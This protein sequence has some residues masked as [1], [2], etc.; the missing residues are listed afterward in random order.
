MTTSAAVTA[1]RRV[2]CRRNHSRCP[3]SAAAVRPSAA[4]RTTRS[5]E[6][7]PVGTRTLL[8]RHRRGGDRGDAGSGT[9]H[10]DLTARLY[11]E[12]AQV[13][14]DQYGGTAGAGVVDD[15]ER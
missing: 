9:Q 4:T 6:E 15:L 14:R 3:R 7:C 12:I 11:G 10:A 1:T 2:L 13:R 5:A 8:A